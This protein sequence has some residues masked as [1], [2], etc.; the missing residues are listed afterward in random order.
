M[1]KILDTRLIEIR[2]KIEAVLHVMVLFIR[3][4]K[5]ERIFRIIRFN[6]EAKLGI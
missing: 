6:E 5:R 3:I 2:R 4:L 1:N